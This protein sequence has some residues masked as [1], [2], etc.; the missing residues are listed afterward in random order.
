M[1][2]KSVLAYS[3]ERAECESEAVDL[4][5]ELR[6]NAKPWGEGKELNHV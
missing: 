1:Q 3:D 5:A 6:S 2:S 4:P